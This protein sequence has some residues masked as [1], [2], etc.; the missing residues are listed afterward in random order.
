MST[1]ATTIAFIATPFAGHYSIKFVH[2][3]H[4]VY[5]LK[6]NGEADGKLLIEGYIKNGEFI[7]K[8]GNYKLDISDMVGGMNVVV[9]DQSAPIYVYGVSSEDQLRAIAIGSYKEVC[10][11]AKK[12]IIPSSMQRSFLVSSGIFVWFT[13]FAI[14]T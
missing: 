14:I 6:H 5:K 9:T 12:D 1:L 10:N 7:T 3:V 8:Q 11:S 4:A 2:G 13:F